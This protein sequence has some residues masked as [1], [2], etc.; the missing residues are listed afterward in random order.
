[1]R[2]IAYFCAVVTKCHSK[3]P[4]AM[5]KSSKLFCAMVLMSALS[6][7]FC[8]LKA[9]TKWDYPVKPGTPRWEAFKTHDEMVKAVQVPNE[10][11]NTLT[12]KE[13]IE[14]CLNYPLYGD[15]FAYNSLQDGFKNNV[16]V[17]SNGV[18]ELLRRRDNAQ[19]LL[20][21]LKN[22]DLLTLESKERVSTSS[23]IGESIW[24]HSFLEVLMSHESVLANAD[25]GQQREIAAIAA[26][27]MLLK[28]REIGMYG[29]QSL[30]SSAYLLGI[31]LKKANVGGAPSPD[32]EMFLRTGLSNDVSLLFE[33]LISNYV[34]F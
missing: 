15:M 25:A 30:E 3:K 32:L 1:M 27:N 13:L 18:Q 8:D 5:K 7:G 29:L 33:E 12:T 22:R 9:Q 14:V 4:K 26:K 31:T 28:E 16:A 10:V 24:E 11:L 19:W 23:K 6:A 34:R 17:N 2:K 21:E 20:D